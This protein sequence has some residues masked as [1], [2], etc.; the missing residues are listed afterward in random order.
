MIS[1]TFV[2]AVGVR[3]TGSVGVSTLGVVVVVDIFFGLLGA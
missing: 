1:F 3:F 2:T